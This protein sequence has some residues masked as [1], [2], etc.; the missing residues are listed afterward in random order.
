[1]SGGQ[2]KDNLLQY[3]T[4]SSVVGV[5]F[6]LA[7]IAFCLAALAFI[8]ELD[9]QFPLLTPD[10]FIFHFQTLISSI[11]ALV[12]ACITVWFIRRQIQQAEN[13]RLDVI[14]RKSKAARSTMQF[15]LTAITEY[16]EVYDEYSNSIYKEACNSIFDEEAMFPILLPEAI[17]TLKNCVEYA[18]NDWEQ[19]ISDLLHDIQILQSRLKRARR[20]YR[21]QYRP[22][23]YFANDRKRDA[24]RLYAKA[25]RLLPYA[26]C[27]IERPAELRPIDQTL[28][29]SLRPDL[30]VRG[31]HNSGSQ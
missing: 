11:I 29:F 2:R 14:F 21:F 9:Q 19:P 27:E 12:G 5:C 3:P 20:P 1:M 10:H 22:T 4:L 16:A 31:I 18:D 30:R 15:S 28:L 17:Y 7:S 24:A 8:A 23:S 26:R 6:I 25:E 13:E